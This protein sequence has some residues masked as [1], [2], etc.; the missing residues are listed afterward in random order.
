[1]HVVIFVFCPVVVLFPAFLLSFLPSF[2]GI[3]A[4]LLPFD[5]FGALCRLLAKRR[6]HMYLLRA[7]L[8]SFDDGGCGVL[9]SG[10]GHQCP[11]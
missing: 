7:G 4:I 8:A 6:L 11:S 9:P 3:D 5:V 10:G 1:M 2:L